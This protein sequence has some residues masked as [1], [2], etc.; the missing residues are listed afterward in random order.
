MVRMQGILRKFVEAGVDVCYN[1]KNTNLVA[2][3]RGVH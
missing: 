3:E 2:V 1:D